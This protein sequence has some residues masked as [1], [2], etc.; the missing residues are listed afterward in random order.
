[1]RNKNIYGLVGKNINY[2]FSKGYFLDKFKKE[3][4]FSCDYLNFD[5]DRIDLIEDVFRNN[6][7]SGLNVTIPY[8]EKIIPYIDELCP[9]A[10]EIGSVN[11]ICFENSKKIG[12]NTD[13][14]GFD[15]TLS[16][17]NIENINHALVLGTGGASKAIRYV[18]SKRNIKYNLVSRSK[19]NNNILYKDLDSNMFNQNL[20][21]INST[22]L[23]TYPNIEEF[24]DIPY[25]LINN[26]HILY[27]LVYNP[28]E[29]IF[30]K[31]GIEKG[32]RVINGLKMLRYQAEKSWEL[33]SKSNW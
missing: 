15:K 6:L 9:I 7:L 16:E 8:K 32:A 24:P 26:N 25:N 27:D 12:Y 22:P 29:T 23:G 21:I 19:K 14:H 2:S 1:L 4:I 5:L 18:L 28:V 10:K 33:W 13:F 11:T 31:K 3:R 30:M 20:L 17:I